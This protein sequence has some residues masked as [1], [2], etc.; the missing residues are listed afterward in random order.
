MKINKTD[1]MRSVEEHFFNSI[2][3]IFKKERHDVFNES[4]I[5]IAEHLANNEALVIFYSQQPSSYTMGVGAAGAMMVGATAAVAA[6]T[7]GAVATLA[8]AKGNSLNTSQ[9]VHITEEAHPLNKLSV[10]QLIDLRIS[11]I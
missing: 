11:N 8:A 1:F 5:K 9:L 10:Q 7:V 3:P 6:A 2:E 4:P